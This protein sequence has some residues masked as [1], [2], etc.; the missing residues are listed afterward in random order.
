VP[1]LL[2]CIQQNHKPAATVVTWELAEAN[3][4]TRLTLVH[5]SFAP[6]IK[7]PGYRIGWLEFLVRIKRMVEVG[8]HWQRPKLQMSARAA[9]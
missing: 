6:D 7:Q 3:S 5:S 1:A 8:P 2:R 4:R 9:A